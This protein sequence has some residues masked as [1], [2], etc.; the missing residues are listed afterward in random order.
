MKITILTL[1]SRGDPLRVKRY[2]PSS[3]VLW[4]TSGRPRNG[5][6]R[7]SN[8]P[9]PWVLI[10]S[11]RSCMS[12]R[13]GIANSPDHSDAPFSY[14]F[15]REDKS[16]RKLQQAILQSP[17]VV[18]RGLLSGSHKPMWRRE[19][20]GLPRLRLSANVYA[21]TSEGSIPVLYAYSPHVVASPDDWPETTL[22]HLGASCVRRSLTKFTYP[23]PMLFHGPT[24]DSP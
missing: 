23:K 21:G 10:T 22:A 24:K 6:R 9:W 14:S 20:L 3:A 11:R 18:A 4:K 2:G 19:V 16:S 1:G 15:N 8:T 12:R 17:A 5:L 7:S 13:S